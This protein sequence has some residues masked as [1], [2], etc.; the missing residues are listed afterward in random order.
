M[1]FTLVLAMASIAT[2][3]RLRQRFDDEVWSNVMMGMNDDT[4]YTKDTPKGY[5]ETENKPKI[6]YE[7][8]ARKKIEAEMKVKQAQAQKEQRE[9]DIEDMNIELLTFSKNLTVENL[10][11]AIKI[12]EKL[13]EQGYPP[14]H[15]RVSAYS[16][17]QK[18]FKH[19]AV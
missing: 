18:G 13:E 6:D 3:E 17:W 14:Q 7:A 11:N 15:F 4:S 1:K 12:K 8:I 19:E 5:A 16:L 9:K 10:K 2:A